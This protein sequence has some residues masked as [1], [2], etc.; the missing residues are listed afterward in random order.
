MTKDEVVAWKRK[1]DIAAKR[2]KELL[3]QMDDAVR[4]RQ[5]QAIF[6]TVKSQ[7]WQVST[8]EDVA[9]VRARWRKLHQSI[10]NPN[11]ATSMNSE[12]GEFVCE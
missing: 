12:Y 4:F 5:L 2:E 7:N 1:R 9:S 6:A 3:R 10:S 8:P 11:H